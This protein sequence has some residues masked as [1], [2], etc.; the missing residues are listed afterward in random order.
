[1]RNLDQRIE[2]EDSL[3]ELDPN[4]DLTW[5]NSEF[6]DELGEGLEE[7]ELPIKVED[8]IYE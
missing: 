4:S 2:P 6:E 8:E 3:S 5:E 7:V 1:M